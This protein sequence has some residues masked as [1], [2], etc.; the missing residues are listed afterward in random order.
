MPQ[1]SVPPGARQPHQPVSPFG[2]ST[3][4]PF[5]DTL[6]SAP[7]GAHRTSSRPVTEG[8]SHHPFALVLAGGGARG[9]A[10]VGVL[11]ALHHHGYTPS[12]I[13]GVSMGAVVGVTYALNPDWYV[14]LLNMNTTGF[15]E[16]LTPRGSDLR[17]RLRVLRASQHT[18]WRMLTGWGAG[19]RARAA[20]EALLVQL[21]RDRDLEEGRIRVAAVA[22]DLLSGERVVMTEGKAAKAAYA[23]AAIAGLLPPLHEDGRLLA[24][25]VYADVAPIDVARNLGPARVVAVDPSPSQSPRLIQTGLQAWLRATE[26]C[27]YQH[28]HLRFAQADLTL[29]PY[30]PQTIDALD[31]LT[32]RTCVAAGIYAVRRALPD[33]HNLLEDTEA[34][35]SQ[36]ANYARA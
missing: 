14:Q 23:S 4:A 22:T 34:S 16:P 30:Y 12:A 17:E 11:Y 28:G 32:R 7:V 5:Y 25:G 3:E 2:V 27:A 21:T 1:A 36:V 24:D 18:F 31:F 10:H 6:L 15:P 26:I 8:R 20:G 9:F 29:R 13:V 33:L 35:T 19:E